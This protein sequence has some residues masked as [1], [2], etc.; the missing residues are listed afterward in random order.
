MDSY[1]SQTT[2]QS[3]HNTTLHN[4]TMESFQNIEEQCKLLVV[5]LPLPPGLTPKSELLNQHK[6]IF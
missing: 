1:R 5:V 6:S 3:D 2:E 4:T